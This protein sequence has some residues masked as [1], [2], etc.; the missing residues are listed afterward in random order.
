MKK[1]LV[2]L[3]FFLMLSIVYS[4]GWYFMAR[5]MNESIDQF[6]RKNALQLDINLYGP[7]PIVTGFPFAPIITYHKGF[8]TNQTNVIFRDMKITGFPIPNFPIKVTFDKGVLVKV[9]R[10]KYTMELDYAELNIDIP[11][12]LPKTSYY[13]DIE[14]WQN[15]VEKV[16]I[17]NIEL[18]K[19]TMELKGSGYVGLDKY[20]QPEML[21]ETKIKGHDEFIEFL[22][23][24]GQ[25]EAMPAMLAK[26][27]LNSLTKID[28]ETNLPYVSLNA[29]ILDRVLF[30]G[31]VRVTKLDRIQWMKSVYQQR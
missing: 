11:Q 5:K 28:P 2:C 22:I 3:T 19:E 15:Q 29:K 13:R 12:S 14:R 21:L 1:I 30:L 24:S 25:I 8:S 16:L 27:G 10:T 17:N 18:K 9:N 31:P 7:K 26:A 20:L 4:A 23:T 6:Y